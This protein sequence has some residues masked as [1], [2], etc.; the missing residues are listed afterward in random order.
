M[1]SH[2]AR[3][4]SD[5]ARESAR[6]E[7][8]PR[9]LSGRRAPEGCCGWP[10]ELTTLAEGA[11]FLA[12][13]EVC[14]VEG[15]VVPCGDGPRADNP[16]E[17]GRIEGV[18]RGLSGLSAAES[19]KDGKRRGVRTSCKAIT[20]RHQGLPAGHPPGVRRVPRGCAAVKSPRTA[21]A[22]AKY[23][24]KPTIGPNSL[25]HFRPQRVKY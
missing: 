23:L 5:K 9:G 17:S 16:R 7:R 12:F 8:N 21:P 1:A 6:F 22:P 13:R 18:P 11:R 19:N 20:S 14:Q 4:R 2:L 24:K 10:S 3:A 25:R 15:L